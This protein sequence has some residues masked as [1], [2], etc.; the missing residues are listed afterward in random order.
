MFQ[1]FFAF[2][3]L[4]TIDKSIIVYRKSKQ[5]RNNLINMEIEKFLCYTDYTLP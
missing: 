3:N 2:N 4:H 5:Y 1:G